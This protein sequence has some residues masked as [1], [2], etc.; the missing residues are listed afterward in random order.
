MVNVDDMIGHNVSTFEFILKR[1]KQEI[2][3]IVYW[4]NRAL[5]AVEGGSYTGIR[6]AK[7]TQAELN[8]YKIGKVFRFQNVVS[9]QKESER[10]DVVSAR[11]EPYNVV[12]HIHGSD[13]KRV[14]SYLGLQTIV[15]KKEKGT[16]LFPSGT[17][18]LVCKVEKVQGVANIYIRQ[19]NLGLTSGRSV[20]LIND[21][22]KSRYLDIFDRI[23]LSPRHN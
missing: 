12:F 21:E 16:I 15:H 20:L 22:K 23:K 6:K 11:S 10:N 14:E 13:A 7:V 8:Y 4:L 1:Y 2:N 5:I 17:E 18:F 19:I 9:A 3:E